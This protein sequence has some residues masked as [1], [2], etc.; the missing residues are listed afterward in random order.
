MRFIR[1]K[2]KKKNDGTHIPKN[3]TLAMLITR[4]KNVSS[5]N[6]PRR[7]ALLWVETLK[8]STLGHCLKL[9]TRHAKFEAHL[10]YLCSTCHFRF[11]QY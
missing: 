2:K 3:V 4:G 8:I 9:L 6:G 1:K 10:H 11:P 7:N 5:S